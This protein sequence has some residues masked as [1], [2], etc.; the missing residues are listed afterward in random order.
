[1]M[2]KK[3]VSQS[4][5]E[6][7][8]LAI[9]LVLLSIV[10]VVIYGYFTGVRLGCD[11]YSDDPA[12][13]VRDSDCRPV[14]END[15]GIGCEDAIRTPNHRFNAAR[16]PDCVCREE[17]SIVFDE[18]SNYYGMCRVNGGYTVCTYGLDP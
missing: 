5:N 13:C 14:S 6:I 17:Q 1:M 10:L 3:G 2:Y 9:K 11:A 15:V 4:T 7:L 12:G 16:D 18:E 8:F